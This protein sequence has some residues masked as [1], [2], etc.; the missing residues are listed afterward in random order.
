MRT[1]QASHLAIP[2]LQHTLQPHCLRR[3]RIEESGLHHAIQFL[4]INRNGGL[5]IQI[6]MFQECVVCR[7]NLHGGKP[8][9]LFPGRVNREGGLQ[10]N[11]TGHLIFRLKGRSLLQ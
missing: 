3:L 4:F 6:Q 7:P 2:E 10:W 1:D 5:K 11:G 9:P 8:R